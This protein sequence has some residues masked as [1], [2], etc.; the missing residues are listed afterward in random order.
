[1][2]RLINRSLLDQLLID[3]KISV[4]D[5]SLLKSLKNN[6]NFKDVEGNFNR[7]NYNDYLSKINMSENEFEKI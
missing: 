3:L 4:G 2:E 5:V 1:M 7:K 6:L